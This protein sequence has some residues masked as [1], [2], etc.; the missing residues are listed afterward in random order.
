MKEVE[1]YISKKTIMYNNWTSFECLLI[2]DGLLIA[3]GLLPIFLLQLIGI[4]NWGWW[5]IGIVLPIIILGTVFITKKFRL[6][7]EY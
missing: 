6:L 5:V 3:L 1:I 2:V 7:E 4:I